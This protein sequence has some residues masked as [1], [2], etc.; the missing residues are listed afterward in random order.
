[1]P[2][3]LD[4]RMGQH[5][6]MYRPIDIDHLAPDPDE[7]REVKICIS[8]A[9]P[10]D[11]ARDRHWRIVWSTKQTIEGANAY[12]VLQIVQERGWNIYT[13]WGP[14]TKYLDCSPGS[15]QLSNPCVSI[16]TINL[17]RRRILE[18][19]ALCTPPVSPNSGGN[20]QDWVASVL[21]QAVGRGVISRQQMEAA[22]AKASQS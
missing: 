2:P 19:I 13:N 14:M 18:S 21:A 22:I 3:V 8:R 20:S 9:R 16:T 10:D 7:D 4:A 6:G 17:A 11:R 12:R 1:M 15:G 5:A